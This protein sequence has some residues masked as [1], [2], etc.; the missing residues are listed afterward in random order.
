MKYISL[1][2]I[3]GLMIWSW[4]LA[5]AQPSF[6]M[7][8]TKRVEDGVESDIHEFIQRKYPETTDI[9][10]QQLYTETV[11]PGEEMN[12]RFRCS[13]QGGAAD[14]DKVA[15]SFEG[16]LHLGSNDDFETWQEL[17]GEIRSSDIAFENGSRISAKEAKENAAADEAA[18]KDEA[19]E[20]A[21]G[22]VELSRPPSQ[23]P[24]PSTDHHEE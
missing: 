9:Y 11:K 14:G 17:G 13:T 15:Q 16:F 3:L 6:S 21:D 12:V 1:V 18:S 20:A 23:P 8:Q 19:T 24:H 2:L 10:C 22:A 5:S 4:S 7:E